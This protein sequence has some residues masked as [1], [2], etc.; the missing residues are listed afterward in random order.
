M[1][2]AGSMLHPTEV[3]QLRVGGAEKTFQLLAE[4]VAKLGL[5]SP[6]IL[7]GY[8]NARCGKID[9]DSELTSI[10]MNR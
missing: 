7:C 4:Q 3:F 5:Q 2:G 1:S 6:V 9:V 10:S 8:L